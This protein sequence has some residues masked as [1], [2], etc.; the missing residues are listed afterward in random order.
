M[1][2]ENTSMNE[3]IRRARGFT[4]AE[5]EPAGDEPDGPSRPGDANGGARPLL[6]EAPD[7]NDVLR[8]ARFGDDG[9]QPKP[10]RRA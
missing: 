4:F 3:I 5:E 10:I 2:D 9:T 6:I 8:R 1:T 7:M